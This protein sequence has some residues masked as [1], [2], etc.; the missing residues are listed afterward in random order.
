[1]ENSERQRNVLPFCS[2]ILNNNN[3]TLA[4]P[5]TEDLLRE[6]DAGIGEMEK[7]ESESHSVVSDSL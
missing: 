6:R 3:K 4:D 2:M 7:S 5:G 1:M